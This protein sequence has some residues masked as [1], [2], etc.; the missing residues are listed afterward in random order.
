M[1][2]VSRTPAGR[3]RDCEYPPVV[4]A[5]LAKM[6]GRGRVR[7]VIERVA[8]ILP[9]EEIDRERQGPRSHIRYEYATH[10]ARRQLVE[11]G[12]LKPFAVSGRGWWEFTTEAHKTA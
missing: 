7:D 11:D 12:M 6:G 10:K 9:L 3:I 2:T 5:A 1:S 4:L 8:R